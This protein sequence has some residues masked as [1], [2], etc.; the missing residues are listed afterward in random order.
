M[1]DHRTLNALRKKLLT[2]GD[3]GA[4][5]HRN[6]IFWPSHLICHECW[7]VNKIRNLLKAHEYAE[8]VGK[9]DIGCQWKLTEKG[10]KWL[11]S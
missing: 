6:G 1:T 9:E 10:E 2:G 4:P 5:S 8:P 7:S 11:K 3:R